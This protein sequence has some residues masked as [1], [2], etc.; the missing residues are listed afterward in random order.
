M[1]K[2]IKVKVSFKDDEDNAEELTSEATDTVVAAAVTAVPADW[3]LTPDGLG[4][5]ER[6]RLLF[7]SSEPRN[8]V[9]TDI[10]D[11]NAWAQ[12]L[13]SNGHA[14]I[15]GY[16]S[17]FR[18][19]GS[20]ADVDARENTG[21]THTSS[22][23]GVPIHWLNGDKAADD[24]AD[25][26]DEDWDEEASMRNESGTTVSAPANVWTGS[27]HDGTESVA[28][29]GS[30]P[31]GN[32]SSSPFAGTTVGRPNSDNLGSGPV[33][34]NQEF[35]NNLDNNFYGLSGVFSVSPPG[36]IVWSAS[37]TVEVSKSPLK[38]TWDSTPPLTRAVWTPLLSYMT[39]T[40]SLSSIC[41]TKSV[42]S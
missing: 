32:T 2:T 28:G 21:T 20:T 27:E 16:S 33:S 31:L 17:T 40:T 30:R 7:L 10:A 41:T 3:S 1:G 24:Y 26:Y 34:S 4:A 8:A 19:V 29:G 13:V 36:E 37:L 18:I 14:D 35:N 6:F 12:G 15:Q 11:Y 22:D 23:M 25:F 9:P 38:H 5:G 39:G 42:A